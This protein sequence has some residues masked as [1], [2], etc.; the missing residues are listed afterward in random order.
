[1]FD[2]FTFTQVDNPLPLI[3]GEINTTLNNFGL[4]CQFRHCNGPQH[5]ELLLNR[6]P[7]LITNHP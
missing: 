7:T 4:H 5:L 6:Q 1:M 2:C 3:H